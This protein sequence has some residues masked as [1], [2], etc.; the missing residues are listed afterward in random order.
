MFPPD[1]PL[2]ASMRI[3]VHG[4]AEIPV[5]G[6]EPVGLTTPGAWRAAAS[7]IGWLW[8]SRLAPLSQPAPVQQADLSLGRAPGCNGSRYAAVDVLSLESE[9]AVPM[10]RRN[11]DGRQSRR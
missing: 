4:N 11:A 1:D 5:L 10:S 9:A 2:R 3:A 7:S 8:H 6:A